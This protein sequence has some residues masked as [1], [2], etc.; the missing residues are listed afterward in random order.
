VAANEASSVDV[1][2][3]LALKEIC[4]YMQWPIGHACYAVPNSAETTVELIRRARGIFRI[5]LASPPFVTSAT[6]LTSRQVWDCPA[7]FRP[8]ESQPGSWM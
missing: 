7:A 1:A 5:L 2:M 3:H 6:P 4:E 8:V